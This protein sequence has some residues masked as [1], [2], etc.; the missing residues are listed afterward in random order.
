M[1]QK[2][3]RIGK[4]LM[5]L[6]VIFFYLPILYMIIFSF[7]DGKSLTSFTGFSLRWYRHMLD[8]SDMMEALSTTF[9]VAVLAT[10]IS[11]I[12]GTISAIGISKSKK[13]VRDL[14]DQVNN[15]PLMNPDLCC[16]LSHSVWK[17]AM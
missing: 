8:S 15:L 1:K 11:T 6:S 7:N 17:K 9:S 12:V 10:I 16:Y 3:R 5:V 4:I 13:V 2:K 14:M